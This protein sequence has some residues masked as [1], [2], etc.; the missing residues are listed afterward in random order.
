[1]LVTF[2]VASCLLKCKEKKAMKMPNQPIVLCI[3]IV[4]LTLLIFTWLT[5][6]SLCELRMKDGNKG[7]ICYPGLRIR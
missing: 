2:R 1:M 4:C 5:R 6:N 3:L 7:G